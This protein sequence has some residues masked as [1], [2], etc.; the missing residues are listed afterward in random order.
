[1][2]D[3]IEKH[4][5]PG[6]VELTSIDADSPGRQATG[7][8][9]E[10]A[11]YKLRMQNMYCCIHVIKSSSSSSGPGMQQHCRLGLAIWQN[12]RRLASCLS[13][14]L[15]LSQ[16][17]MFCS[18]APPTQKYMEVGLRGHGPVGHN[19]ALKCHL[20]RKKLKE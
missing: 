16:Q 13:L 2:T 17:G 11:Q 15:A 14:V 1:M 10:A 8:L 3:H 7:D 4:H 12:E 5:L 9:L 6:T 18:G 20:K 19:C